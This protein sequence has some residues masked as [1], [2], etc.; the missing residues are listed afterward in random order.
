M[1]HAHPIKVMC[2]VLE[3][4]RSGYYQW[5]SAQ[6]PARALQTE[7]FWSTLK[8]EPIYRRRFATCDEATTAIFDYVESFYNRTAFTRPLASK[9]L[10]LTNPTSINQHTYHALRVS[11]LSGEAQ[12]GFSRCAFGSDFYSRLLSGSCGGSCGGLLRL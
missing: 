11:V 2:E 9:A 4:S 5:Q 12:V 6:S 8:H 1:N 10:S 3:V 7:A